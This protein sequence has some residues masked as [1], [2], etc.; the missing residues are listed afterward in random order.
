MT[1]AVPRQRDESDL[2]LLE[3]IRLTSTEA[4]T[5]T[6]AARALLAAGHPRPALRLAQARVARARAA[7]ITSKIADRA[8][9]TLG[10]ALALHDHSARYRL[11]APALPAHGPSPATGDERR[12]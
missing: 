8:A 2:V 12:R 4:W 7:Q 1:I 6:E 10:A 9:A 5:V 11:P 3:L